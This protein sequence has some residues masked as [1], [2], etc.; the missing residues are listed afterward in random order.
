MSVRLLLPIVLLMGAGGACCCGGER[1]PEEKAAAE[2]AQGERDATVAAFRS[3]LRRV[4]DGLGPVAALAPRACDPAAFAAPPKPMPT[5]ADHYRWEAEDTKVWV[6]EPQH[7]ERTVGVTVEAN[8]DTP[9]LAWT[10]TSGWPS[11]ERVEK[12]TWLAKDLALMIGARPDLIVVVR[13]VAVSAPKITAKGGLLQDAAFEGGEAVGLLDVWSLGAEPQRLCV[14][15]WAA[16]SSES[17]GGG[18]DLGPE[19][20][21]QELVEED[22]RDQVKASV[23]A[24]LK[25]LNPAFEP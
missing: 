25:Q 7:L 20:D 22:F 2:A 10:Q 21:P 23:T 16:S 24:A 17:V 15:P 19:D 18:L 14:H 6:V 1:T 3:S 9:T 5:G 12:E 8:P 11:L 13:L 4:A